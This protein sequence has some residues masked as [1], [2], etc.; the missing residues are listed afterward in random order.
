M[1]GEGYVIVGKPGRPAKT[2]LR[3]VSCFAYRSFRADPGRSAFFA[4]S[5]LNAF[6]YLCVNLN[7]QVPRALSLE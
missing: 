6:A 2:I 4:I 1:A 3:S 5:R 7:R